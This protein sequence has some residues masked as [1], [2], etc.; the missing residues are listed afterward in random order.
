[1]QKIPPDVYWKILE[2]EETTNVATKVKNSLTTVYNARN[3]LKIC[4]LKL[5]ELKPKSK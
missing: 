5:N 1:M 3:H 4:H 2:C